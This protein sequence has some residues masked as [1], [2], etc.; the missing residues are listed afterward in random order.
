MKTT[1][2]ERVVYIKGIVTGCSARIQGYKKVKESAKFCV[3]TCFRNTKEYFDNEYKIKE[4]V[5][6][7]PMRIIIRDSIR[8]EDVDRNDSKMRMNLKE[9]GTQRVRVKFSKITILG[10]ITDK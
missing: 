4:K 6:K 10:N 7:D 8:I 1:V 9:K 5:D 2:W 3:W